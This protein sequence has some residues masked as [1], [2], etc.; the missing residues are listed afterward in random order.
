PPMGQPPMGQPPMGQPPMGQDMYGM[1]YNPYQMQPQ[2][3]PY[4]NPYGGQPQML[5][6]DMSGLR[7]AEF[8]VYAQGAPTSGP[9]GTNLNLLMGVVLDISVVVGRSKQKIKD[10]VDFGE[11]TLIELD[12][13]TG[14]PAEI[15]VNGQLLAYGDVIVVGDN[16]GVRVT[17]IVGTKELLDSLNTEK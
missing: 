8:P 2:F 10:I 1:Q 3:N 5:K 7:N 9:F 14:A 11:G 15:V 16:F 17:E 4:V 6:P 12:K 13:Q